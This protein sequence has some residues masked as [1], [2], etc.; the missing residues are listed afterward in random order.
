MGLLLII[1]G[2]RFSTFRE[3]PLVCPASKLKRGLAPMF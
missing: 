2:S 1:L 3:P